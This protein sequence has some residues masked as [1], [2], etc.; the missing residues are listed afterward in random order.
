[1]KLS[2]RA[3]RTLKSVGITALAVVLA[4]L[5]IWLIWLLWLDRYVVYTRDGA[6]LDFSMSNRELSGEKAQPPAENPTV[7]IYYNEGEGALNISTE[8]A[9]LSGY[10]IDQTMLKDDP[11]GVLTILK[12]LP[13][14]TPVLIELKDIIGNF[15]YETTHGPLTTKLDT[16]A[17][18]SIL[19]Y[20]GKSD[21][22][23]MAKLPALRDRMYGLDHV[24]DGLPTEK[25]Y[26]WVD[27]KKCYWLN[28]GSEGTQTRLIQITKELQAMGFD[29]VVFNE[30]YF[31]KTDKIVFKGD[32]TQTLVDA[33]AVLL[34][35]CTSDR[36]TVSF[37][38]EDPAFPLPEGRTRMYLADR[39]AADAKAL[40][41]QTSLTDT[42]VKLVFLTDVHDTRFNDY[43][44]LR[45]ITSAQLEE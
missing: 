15:F 16:A 9:Q 4:L 40:A 19:E 7:S 32:K 1:M 31:P 30:F 45:P 21:L 26:L 23:A 25:G 17:V 13:A 2:Y 43:G 41:A 6:V 8:L 29:E 28:P 37:L 34:Q 44:V 11:E 24:P 36:F 18:A 35:T 39:A 3:R 42:A 27:D 10:Y 14:Q 12:K 33:A 20:L 5:L 38:V 22:Y